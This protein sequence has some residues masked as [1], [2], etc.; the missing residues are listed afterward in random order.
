MVRR[1]RQR[2][3]EA[4]LPSPEAPFEVSFS[5]AESGAF[6]TVCLSQSLTVPRWAPDLEWGRD[7]SGDGRAA[8]RLGLVGLTETRVMPFKNSHP[9]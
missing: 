7:A 9:V 5:S 4:S 6:R 2:S 1:N 8:S 3:K